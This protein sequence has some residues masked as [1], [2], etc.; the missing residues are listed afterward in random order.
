MRARRLVVLV[1]V[2]AVVLGACGSSSKSSTT[3]PTSVSGTAPLNTTLGTGVTADAVKVGIALSDFSCIK[4]FVD[5]VREGQQQIYQAV[6][7]YLNQHGGVAGRK[8]V[9]VFDQFCPIPNAQLLAQVCTHLTDDEKV[10]AVLGN[11][12]DTTGVG[13]ECIAKRHKTLMMVFDLTREIA[14]KAPPGLIVFPG[15]FPERIDDVLTKLL[16]QQHTLDGKKVAILGESGTKTA[17]TKTLQP[18]LHKIGAQLGS[19]AILQIAGTDTTA[20]QSQ[21]DSFIERWKGEG[22][23]AVFI[24]GEDVAQKQFVEKIRKAMPDV[25]LITD[26]G[27]SLGAGQDEVKAHANP[28]PYQGLLYASGP[29]SAEYDASPNWQYCANIYKQMTGKTAPNEEAVIPLPGDPSKRLDTYGA[30]SDACQVLTLF[31]EI[32]DKAGKYLNDDSWANAV[33]TFGPIRDPG[34][35]QYASLGM[36]KY[37]TNDTFRLVEFDVNTGKAGDWKPLSPLQNITGS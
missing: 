3:T 22:V 14:Q 8:I 6:I 10:F 26:I 4:Q 27:D 17:I 2:L 33:N 7:D 28:N 13:Q 31:T 1:V 16:G 30:I 19:T 35:G 32:A 20:A 37:D 5:F 12:Y 18:D 24:S 15:T 36:N 25:V 23:G 21:L 34:G 11:V 9:P 29:T